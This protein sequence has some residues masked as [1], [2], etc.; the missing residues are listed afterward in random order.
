MQCHCI[1]FL[2]TLQ[3]NMKVF[4]SILAIYMMTV[5]LMPCT[6]MYEKDNFQNHNHSEELTHQGSHD[7]QETTDMCSP[8]C[9]CGCCG[10]VSGIVLQCNVY[11]LVKAKT[12]DLSKPKVYYK[13]TFIS[14]YLGKIWQPPKI[15]A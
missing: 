13:C 14:H 7:H 5:F 9:L 10:I 8:F 12:F 3:K 11:S 15:N 1:T 6:D 4:Y 2:L